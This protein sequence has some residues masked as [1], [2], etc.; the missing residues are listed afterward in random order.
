MKDIIINEFNEH[1]RTASMLHNLA[2]LVASSAQK[3]IESLKN[4]GKLLLIGNG[5]SAADAQHIAAELIGRYK[6]NRNGLPAIAL[7][8][9]TS[10][11]TAIGND[12]GYE[13][14]FERQIQALAN[15]G[16]VLIAISTSGTSKNV[17]DALRFASQLDCF[18]I[19]LSGKNG[20]EMNNVCDINIV[21]PS[22][23][24]ARIQVMH[25]TIEHAI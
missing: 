8:T 20:G 10:S 19:G 13:R 14:V 25:F 9:D 15:M 21:I 5:G 1:I 3:C 16:D 12:F 23:D 2:D 22:E 11:L 4:N 17:I 24:S 18:T 7:T 6:T